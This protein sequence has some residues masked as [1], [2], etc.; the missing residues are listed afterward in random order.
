[1]STDKQP[2]RWT[3]EHDH[4]D[5]LSRLSDA[6][7]TALED[8][9]DAGD[10]VRGIFTL[11]DHHASG[12]AMWGY[13]DH[14]TSEPIFDLIRQAGVLFA[15]IGVKMSV[16]ADN[17]SEA[18]TF[19]DF[20]QPP[21]AGGGTGKPMTLVITSSPGSQQAAAVC[22]AVK[23]G[24]KSAEGDWER[25]RVIILLGL[26]EEDSSSVLTHG[27][28]RGSE[29]AEALLAAF[30]QVVRAEGGDILLLSMDQII[31]TGPN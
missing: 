5:R 26:P 12:A 23:E 11:T 31:G 28:E 22:K 10:D 20:P 4:T 27:I 8:H 14:V 17:G 1:M 13:E 18:K 3:L 29:L 25:T 7:T 2:P 19:R 30:Q 9:P 24:V 15:A 21:L 16:E 6:I